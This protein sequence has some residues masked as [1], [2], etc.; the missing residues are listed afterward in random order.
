ML[1]KQ[2]GLGIGAVAGQSNK[3]WAG[4]GVGRNVT[5]HF[6]HAQVSST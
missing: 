1:Y 2:G 4:G 3:V 5:D 6:H